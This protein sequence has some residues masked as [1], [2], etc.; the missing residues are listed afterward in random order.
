[1]I[2]ETCPNVSQ[3][4]TNHTSYDKTEAN[5][6]E[7][8]KN[9]LN[10]YSKP[11]SLRTDYSFSYNSYFHNKPPENSPGDYTTFCSLSGS[12]DD[13]IAIV[14][15]G[16]AITSSVFLWSYRH[17]KNFIKTDL[18]ILDVDN[19]IE[20]EEGNKTY[21]PLLTIEHCTNDPI[22]RRFCMVSTSPSHTPHWHRL[23]LYF[24]LPVT[25][26]DELEIKALIRY[27]NQYHLNGAIDLNAKDVSRMFYGNTNGEW[28]NTDFHVLP[29]ELID[30]CQKIASQ[31]QE[32]IERE[33][34]ERSKQARQTKH[35]ATNHDIEEALTYI[36]P[37]SSYDDWITI[38]FALYNY[39]SGSDEGFAL[40]DNWSEGG[41]KYDGTDKLYR[42]WQSFSGDV[43]QPITINSL[44][45]I[46]IDNG[47]KP[48][49]NNEELIDPQYGKVI[50][51]GKD[52]L[53]LAQKSITEDDIKECSVISLAD[54]RRAIE[55]EEISELKAEL[56]RQYNKLSKG[57]KKGFGDGTLRIPNLITYNRETTYNPETFY[58]KVKKDFNRAPQIVIPSKY[59]HKGEKAKIINHLRVLGLKYVFDNSQTGSGKSASISKLH[60]II[61]LD[62]NY[63]N[64]S[65][66]E[67]EKAPAL[68]PRTFYGLYMVDGK[69]QAD[70]NEDIRK[71]ADDPN[72]P[73]IYK[74]A[75]GNCHLKSAFRLLQSKGYDAE[76]SS[77]PCQKCQFQDNCSF[78]LGKYKN[79]TKD[80]IK[81]MITFGLGR[82]HPNQLTIDKYNNSFNNWGLVWEEVG[83][84]QTAIDYHCSKN[85]IK[86]LIVKLVQA[87]ASIIEPAKREQLINVLV[88]YEKILNPDFAKEMTNLQ[89]K[90]HGL[91]HD[92][93]W[94]KMPTLPELEEEEYFSLLDFIVPNLDE[95]LPDT[96][97]KVEKLSYAD[98][99]WNG[100]KRSA[101]QFMRDELKQELLNKLDG[102]SVN[103]ILLL[104]AI[105]SRNPDYILSTQKI[106]TKNY[107]QWV[108]GVTTPNKTYSDLAK[109]AKFNLFL[110]ATANPTHVKA[111]FDI[112]DDEPLVTITTEKVLLDNIKV[113][114][115][116]ITG[117]GSNNWSEEA[118]ARAK[119]GI[120][121]IKAK[122][123]NKKIAVMTLKRY[124]SDLETNY[125]YGKHDRG[126]NEL[127]GYDGI[128]FV[129]TPYINLGDVQREYYILFRGKQNA[130]TFEQFYNQKIYELRMQGVGRTRAQ[131]FKDKVF[132][133]FY[134]TT[135]ED[136]SYLQEMGLNYQE[137]NGEILSPE[138]GRKGDRTLNK[139]KKAV[140]NLF[141]SGVKATC[142]A[143]ANTLNLTKQGVSK[144]VKAV[145][146]SWKEFIDCQLSLYEAY[147]GEVDKFDSSSPH[148]SED[149]LKDKPEDLINLV[150]DNLSCKGV[151]GFFDLVKGLELPYYMAIRLLWAVSGLFDERL[152]HLL[153]INGDDPNKLL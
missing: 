98:R 146:L 43:E 93:I 58:N 36:S 129:G 10:F 24:A 115:I 97:F 110:D 125:W 26:T 31:E 135:G 55:N 91:C 32:I 73:N 126:T 13:L 56:I 148:W 123:P 86:D 116:N 96:N 102:L 113:F 84:L 39:F 130:P 114:N 46:A 49:Y 61:Y 139:I 141:S 134:L 121:L 65:N 71:Q 67:L 87:D 54:F 128:I 68:T 95:Y 83:T 28:Y 45:K 50:A 59:S 99:K 145:G 78:V 89:G 62:N 17:K 131:H 72:V 152:P 75:E 22:L 42:K 142:Q 107:D 3:P 27:L 80:D 4:S 136:L 51:S 94:E 127:M 69:I 25:L 111:I 147:K 150:I 63:K 7:L 144:A 35:I 23:R 109:E 108:I 88:W 18:I 16:K 70:P 38:G 19:V 105:F 122:N 85:D 149:Y 40:F 120:D 37:D 14:K 52:A 41:H 48:V 132:H 90:Y 103:P 11:A 124:A 5:H 66:P 117:L 100:V 44:F 9:L 153:I 76:E 57:Y 12:I 101:E 77:L 53:A 151:D 104:D 8:C 1:M 6:I 74:I 33:K 30:H 112:A 20:D 118:I 34:L 60:N 29:F 15:S 138:L 106:T 2:N 21:N 119:A 47:Y 81:K 143:V 140:I 137:I 64:P 82:M 92:T 79:E 133:Q